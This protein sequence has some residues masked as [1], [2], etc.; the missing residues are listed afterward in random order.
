MNLKNITVGQV[1]KNYKGMCN[2]LEEKE[3]SSNSKIAQLKEWSRY[4]SFEKDGQKFI[5]TEIYDIPLVKND[6]RAKG[7]NTIY[8]DYIE[9]L[10]MHYLSHKEEYTDTFSTKELY[11]IL[12]FVNN[13][14]LQYRQNKNIDKVLKDLEHTVVTKFDVNNFISRT[15]YNFNKILFRA[16]N[17]LKSRRLLEYQELI[18]IA[19]IIDE[20]QEHEIA[21]DCEIE[22]ILAVEKQVLSEMGFNKMQSVFLSFS[23]D[24]FYN[25]VNE[26]LMEKYQWL[27]S[28][29]RYKVIFLSEQIKNEIPQVEIELKKKL[30]NTK[31]SDTI[32]KEAENNIVK[33]EKQ[34]KEKYEK[35]IEGDGIWGM[36]EL[37]H[38]IQFANPFKYSDNYVEAQHSLS[39]YFLEI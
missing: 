24:K 14:Y 39:K 1:I 11:Q 3:L 13:N 4:F 10:L 16:L 17:S 28:Y 5:I 7:N 22:K 19:K 2:L 6:D 32:N 29:K 18:Y 37:E 20:Q 21:T 35:L 12:A 38:Y 36:Y 23:V 8:V 26:I 9:I 30:L 33:N 15:Q 25:R 34:I 31:I 27:Y